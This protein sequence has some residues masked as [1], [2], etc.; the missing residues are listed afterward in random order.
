MGEIYKKSPILFCQLRFFS[1][2]CIVK[3]I[4]IEIMK[5][6]LWLI[7]CLMTM[8]VSVNAQNLLKIKQMALNEYKSTL[9]APSK[10]ILTDYYGNRISVGQLKATYLKAEYDTTILKR[11]DCDSVTYYKTTYFPCY[12]VRIVG[13]AMVL[14]G[15]YK[16]VTEYYYVYKNKAYSN[17]PHSDEEK[18]FTK[19]YKHDKNSSLIPLD[20][21]YKV[22]D[23]VEQMPSYPGGQ[24][25]LFEYL[26]KSIKYPVVAE[27]NGIQ[28]RVIVSFIVERDGSITDVKVVKSVDSSLDKEAKRVV[29][30]MP[31]WIPG[32]QNGSAVRVKY[33]L[34]VTFKLKKFINIK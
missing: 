8:V 18:L 13:E 28:G 4:T 30:S 9:Y 5:K 27:E 7:V 34:P 12:V 25:A 3:Q 32:K 19:E 21:V 20:Y 23:V 1:Y 6:V 29:Q 17:R 11:P 15:G 10:F 22:Y 2:L 14:A 24:S 26:N 16:Q 31:R 33:T